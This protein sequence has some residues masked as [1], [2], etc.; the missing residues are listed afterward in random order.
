MPAATHKYAHSRGL[1]EHHA[2]ESG[3]E[4]PAEMRDLDLA[5]GTEVEVADTD[6]DTGRPIVAWT[7]TTGTG[8]RTTVD[9]EFFAEHFEPLHAQPEGM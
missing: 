7:D 3:R 4:L 8:R 5:P 9:A 1:G 6:E 2:T